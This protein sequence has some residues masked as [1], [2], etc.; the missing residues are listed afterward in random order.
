MSKHLL[1]C[2]LFTFLCG[3]LAACEQPVT[4]AAPDQ[5]KILR[6]CPGFEQTGK[7]PLAHS[8]ECGEL[9]V[10]ENPLEPNGR[11]I[12]LSILRLPAISPTAHPDP[13]VFIQGGP[14]GSSVTMAEM[15]Q[16]AFADVRRNRDLLFV[17]QRGTG[18]SSPLNCEQLNAADQQLPEAQQSAKYR[19]ILQACAAKFSPQAQ[20]YTT[21]YA[22][23]DLE[24]VRRAL[25]YQTLNIWGGSYGTRVALAYAREY[26]ANTRALILDGVAPVQIAL[27]KYFAEDA[28]AALRG[29]N[30]ACEQQ[31]G[32]K[33]LYGDLVENAQSVAQR[34]S[35]A[36]ARGASVKIEFEHPKNQQAT[37]LMLSAKH[38]AE[39]I[40]MALY[41]RDLT[42]LLPRAIADAQRED[43]RLVAAL[44]ALASE[45]LAVTGISEG[46]R[47]SVI[48]NEDAFFIKPQDIAE[49]KLFLGL[50]MLKDIAEVC[51]FWPKATLPD[52]YFAPA[53][54]AV[55]ALLLS[56]GHDPVTPAR[57]AQW[58]AEYLP[59]S[60]M[61][62]APGG[63]H[64][65]S[66]EGC[67][68]K[69]IS[70]FIDLGDGE[71]LATDCINAIRPLPMVLGANTAPAE[72]ATQL[73]RPL[74]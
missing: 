57:W 24:Q 16:G 53:P 29:V 4:S 8:A 60:V 59:R 2:G 1:R 50:N 40:F 38:F 43:Y 22:V 66:M 21:P 33:S 9:A 13:L 20:F 71:T 26:P 48:C 42:V 7:P 41:S 35:L 52:A 3:L 19:E 23:A 69:L 63:H 12:S 31:A 73:T 70:Q 18:Q 72:N 32:C 37:T 36:D 64:V 61:L 14:G 27:P 47:Y 11:K 67:V 25:G 30:K 10:L 34:L 55:P 39:L 5:T 68:P 49:A 15:I 62:Q 51:R 54:S 58:A 28:I 65:V 17:D 44:S 56:G 46:M 6:P 74:P 45:Q